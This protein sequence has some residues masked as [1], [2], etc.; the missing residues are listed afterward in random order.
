M[1]RTRILWFLTLPFLM[2]TVLPVIGM[3]L[4]RLDSPFLCH[5]ILVNAGGCAGDF[6]QV[7]IFLSQAP[8]HALIRNKGW[9]SYWTV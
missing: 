8:R 5:F 7:P 1:T 4:F 2:L 9:D 6:M 3:W